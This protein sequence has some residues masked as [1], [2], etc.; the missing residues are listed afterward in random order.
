MSEPRA[1]SGSSRLDTPAGRRLLFFSLY[2][3]EGA[4]IGYLWLALPTRLRAAGVP[5]EQ[6]TSLTSLLVLPWTFKF[7]VAPLVDGLRTPRWGRRHFAIASQ[8]LMGATLV[9]TLAFDPV[10]QLGAL[11]WLLLAHA[12]AAATQD[13]SI[14]A[15][16]IASTAPEERGRLN[17]WMQA[18]MMVGRAAMGGGALVLE[19]YVGPVAVVMILAA[20]TTFSIALVVASP[21]L[22][23]AP[24]GGG[25]ARVR[26]LLRELVA[27]LGER[28]TWAGLA[29]ALVGGAAFKALDVVLGPFLVDRGYD[30]SE[31]GWFSAGPMIV[32]MTVG[33][34][35]GGALADR[36]PRPR[37]V[38]GA[39]VLVVGSVA[40]LAV[41]DV[42]RGGVGGAH[43]LVMLAVCAF[44]IGLYT[45]SSYALFMDLTRPAIAATQ[46]SAFM[47]ATN[48]C[49]SW[50]VWAMGRLHGAQGYARS[51]L[52]LSAISLLAI[53]LV[54]GL[55]PRPRPGEPV[56]HRTRD[57]VGP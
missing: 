25:V 54:L 35:V 57:E 7:L 4:P 24:R 40:S 23:T 2:L 46:F 28:G 41:V 6:I 1:P 51:L 39:L 19:R 56:E 49:E 11:T 15:L 48:G 44:A 33:A 30:K 9:A 8:L 31:V 38:A 3:S 42:A 13:V 43:L 45:S 47:G 34:V 26:E 16:C 36:L 22:E 12:C 10:R 17:G 32:C 52:V 20:L 14:D 18:G 27:A 37:F 29:V 50:S 55:R 21:S 5:V 53:P